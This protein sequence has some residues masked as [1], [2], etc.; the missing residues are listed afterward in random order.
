MNGKVSGK[1]NNEEFANLDLQSYI[2]MSDGRAYTAV[3]KIPEPI[4]SDILSLQVLGSV[5]GWAFAKPVGETVN[6]FQLTGGV[7]NHTATLVFTNT[8]QKIVVRHKYVG[9]DVYDQVRLE[10]D[11]QGE[12][13]HLPPDAG[14]SFADYEEH[15]TLTAPNTVQS[16]A[17]RSFTYTNLDGTQVSIP[18]SIE[19]SFVFNYCKSNTS[20]TGTTWKFKIEKN[21]IGYEAR[22]QIA[23]YGLSSK[24]KPLGGKSI[25]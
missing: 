12:I 10:V 24:V 23:R 25:N 17:T 1:I 20:L 4:G 21:F 13:P 15:Y 16:S 2:V 5:L 22:E 3:S 18:F 8:N 14:V 19:Q 11:I 9:L 7:F 6:G